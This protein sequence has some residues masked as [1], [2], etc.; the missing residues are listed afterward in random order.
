MTLSYTCVEIE[1]FY[2]TIICNNDKLQ[3]GLHAE[4]TKEPGP[5]AGLCPGYTISRAI[6]SDAIR[7]TRG[8]RFL[9]VDLTREPCISCLSYSP[10]FFCSFEPDLMVLSILPIRCERWIIRLH[11]KIVMQNIA[12]LLSRQLCLYTFPILKSDLVGGPN[13]PGWKGRGRLSIY[14]DK[15]ISISPASCCGH[16]S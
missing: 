16:G 3:V 15:K 7:L 4:E 13:D 6:L 11:I 10:H 5:G 8:D 9:T 2:N 1:N 14:L 12:R